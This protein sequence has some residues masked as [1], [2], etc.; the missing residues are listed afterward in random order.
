MNNLSAYRG[1][2]FVLNL[3]FM[4]STGTAIDISGWKVYLTIKKNTGNTDA[5]A[6]KQISVTCPSTPASGHE[7]SEAG[8]LTMQ[9]TPAETALLNGKYLYDVQYIDGTTVRTVIRAEIVF[10]DD[11]TRSIT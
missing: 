2:S 6:D 3:A 4:D 8:T 5:L 9:L 11:V 10:I 1:D 7:A